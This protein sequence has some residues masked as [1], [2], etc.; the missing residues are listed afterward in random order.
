MRF[1]HLH[2]RKRAANYLEPY[3]SKK[4]LIR[5]LDQVVILAGIVGMVMTLPQLSNIFIDHNAAGVSA[6]SWGAYAV[7]DL[8]WMLYGFVHKETPLIITYTSW[9]VLNTAVCVGALLYG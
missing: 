3:P 2:I 9:L 7:I 5:L 4:F 6:L 1:L 8:P